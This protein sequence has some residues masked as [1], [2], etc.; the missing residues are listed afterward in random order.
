M[1]CA[2]TLKTNLL[3]EETAVDSAQQI[4]VG[5]VSKFCTTSKLRTLFAPFGEIKDINIKRNSKTGKPKSYGFVTFVDTKCAA[6]A[7]EQLDGFEYFGRKL[8]CDT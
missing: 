6:R 7:L 1:S 8:R 5:D 4:F 3:Q 2:D